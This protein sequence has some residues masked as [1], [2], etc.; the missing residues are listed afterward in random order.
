MRL[1]KGA[2]RKKSKSPGFFRRYAGRSRGVRQLYT[3]LEKTKEWVENN[4]YKL[5]IEAQNAKLIT[6]NPIW[7]DLAKHNFNRPFYSEHI[8]VA[9]RNFSEMMFALSL[10]D[11]PFRSP[12]HTQKRADKKLTI[13][14]GGSLVAFHEEILES[15]GQ[16]KNVPILVSQNFFKH[17]D[18]YRYVHGERSDKYVSEEFVVHTV[19]GCQIVLTN[20]T[21]STK[22]LQ[23]LLQIPAGAVPVMA[24]HETR[25]L[26]L[27]LPAFH[28]KTVEYY[29][30]F[31]VR[32]R[33]THYPVH[34]SARDKYVASAKPLLLNVVDTP[35][36]IDRS[37]WAYVSQF[38]TNEEVL[39]FMR[40]ENMNRHKLSMIAFRMKDKAF[41]QAALSL[42]MAPR[43][44]ADRKCLPAAIVITNDNA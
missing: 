20:P 30:Y 44:A 43:M 34:V 10:L 19:Y 33:Y 21:S 6:V 23:V 16:L 28:T 39:A 18:R 9:H 29:F 5:P 2:A 40:R 4:Y 27:T 22:K 41:Y 15:T 42:L 36:K 3:Q 13:K 24:G 7:R 1:L 31:P 38:G 35:T 25:S 8:A 12:K 17:G 32:G 14:A 11:L 26:P 37:S